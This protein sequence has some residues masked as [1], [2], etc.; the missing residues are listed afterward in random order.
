MTNRTQMLGTKATR[1]AYVIRMVAG[2]PRDVEPGVPPGLTRE[3][4]CVSRASEQPDV[5][6]EDAALNSSHNYDRR[7]HRQTLSWC[8]AALIFSR[9]PLVFGLDPSTAITQYNQ[10]VWNEADGLPQGTVQAITQTRE[11]YLWIGTRDG[12]ARFDG[13]KFTVFQSEHATGLESNDIRTIYEDRSGQLWIGTFNGGVSRFR[14]GKFT[15]Y[16]KQDGLPSSGV[17]DLCEDRQGDLWMGTWNGLARYRD[18]RFTV[19]TVADGLTG[20]TCWSI[21]EDKEGTL[22][23]GTSGGL[24]RLTRGRLERVPLPPEW[25][26]IAVRKVWADPG[27]VIWIGTL[28]AGL[29]RFCDD[30]FV[31][32]TTREGLPDNRIRDIHQDSDG[33]VWIATWRGLARLADGKIASYTDRDGLPHSFVEALTEDREGNLWLGTHG[34]GL[35]R[36]R[37]G[38]VA[39]FTTKEGLASNSAKCVFASREGTIWIGTDGGG[40]SRYREGTFTHFTTEDGLP[41]NIVWTIGEDSSGTIWVGTG[42]PT[43][44]CALKQ[45]GSFHTYTR[46]E[47]F[48]V[49]RGTR[50]VYGDR[51]GNLWAGGGA[52]GLCRFRDGTFTLYSMRDGLPGNL[53]R[54]I[55]EDREGN[56]WVATGN[57]LCRLRDGRLTCFTEK[58]GLAHNAVYCILQDIEGTLWF[59]T[60]GG[61]TRYRAGKFDSYKSLDG[62]FQ[63]VIYQIVE[64]NQQTLW[65]SS[66]RG[67]F[68]L[69]TRALDEFSR[70]L[71]GRLPCVEHGI[72]EGMK[73]TQCE[74]GSAPAGCRAADGRL[75]FPTVN[76]VV[77]VD[78][79]SSRR[80][81]RPPPVIIEQVY[82][83]H[84]PLDTHIAAKLRPTA[85]E[86]S[87]HYTALSFVAPE[88]V[89]FQYKLEGLN[90]DWVDAENRRVAYFEKL[91]PGAYRFRIRACNNDGVWNEAD[92]AFALSLAPHVYQTA[93]FR[94]LGCATVTGLAW[95]FHRRRMNRAKL[96]FSLVLAERNRIARDLHDTL[97]QGFAGI[98][99][100]L[101]AVAA[102]IVEA[103]VQAQ[104][105]LQVALQM[106]RQSLAEARRSVLNLRSSTSENGDLASALAQT[107]RRLSP[108]QSVEVQSSI[109]GSVRSL[110]AKIEDNLLRIGQEAIVNSLKYA[111]AGHLWIELDY[112]DHN[113]VL[114]VR[115]DGEGFDSARLSANEE[116][117]F[118]LLGMR[119]RARQM[120][121]SLNVTSSPGR[122][123]GVVLEIP[124]AAGNRKTVQ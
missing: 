119:E 76:G 20:A 61:L 107:A 3:G 101:E 118:G 100:Q 11:G 89:R 80:N 73:T 86:L 62:L 102:R 4:I 99:F 55:D 9:A 111:H 35:A 63:N 23:I 122:G 112:L 65:M 17:L 92:K 36:L 115:D 1:A 53:V 81:L 27:G 12:L 38:K 60:Q 48:P 24:N 103:P 21:C 121:G 84:Q 28:G 2:G 5:G 29:A 32:Y 96:Q 72:A 51:A 94:A 116:P 30:G 6:W 124:T 26:E 57:G 22:W 88:K 98:G 15:C 95:S 82:V 37:D 78:P 85:R 54:A 71:I 117:H 18:G 59:G 31:S 66:N 13:V 77:V 14:D 68:K 91:R 41:S 113:V 120:G 106:V 93:W 70:G 108:N 50:C 34:G 74:G 45:D 114:R 69:S 105:H 90:Q 19:Y 52:G 39:V 42:R 46:A 10:R 104:N 75:W 25:Q 16:K 109:V 8:L 58:D 97:A 56:L 49:D 44:L 47:G 40:L 87:I 43:A 67:I 79:R 7:N 123:T 110:P 33:N 64:D 83:D